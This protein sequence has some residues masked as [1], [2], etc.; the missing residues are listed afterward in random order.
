VA[1]AAQ[2]IN[3]TVRFFSDTLRRPLVSKLGQILSQEALPSAV[4][5]APC[6]H[7]ARFARSAAHFR[8][9]G[10]CLCDQQI[11]GGTK[12]EIVRSDFDHSLRACARDKLLAAVATARTF[13]D[14]LTNEQGVRMCPMRER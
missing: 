5:N 11:V 6:S 3:R 7:A 13:R 14:L 12:Y 9:S 10:C 4:M 2:I 1:A 8:P